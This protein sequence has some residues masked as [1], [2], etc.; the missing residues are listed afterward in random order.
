MWY[1]NFFAFFQ[2][3][4]IKIINFFFMVVWFLMMNAPIPMKPTINCQKIHQNATE[5]LKLLGHK[6]EIN[7]KCTL[8]EP[9]PF[10][11][12]HFRVSKVTERVFKI[13][14]SNLNLELKLY[15]HQFLGRAYIYKFARA[16]RLSLQIRISL[17]SNCPLGNWAQDSNVTFETFKCHLLKW[18]VN[19]DYHTV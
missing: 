18:I 12:W 16:T 1:G 6:W 3:F 7:G 5:V 10:K 2:I 11:R 14:A 15:V 9:I 8:C 19:N 4:H 13:I 17:F